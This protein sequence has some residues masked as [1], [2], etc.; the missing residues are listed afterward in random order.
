[1]ELSTRPSR[2]AVDA[3]T[4]AATEIIANSDN[5]PA[6][7]DYFRHHRDR[8]A[9]DHDWIRQTRRDGETVCEVGA[10]PFF[11]TRALSLS[12][13]DVRP[14]DLPGA[15]FVAAAAAARVSPVYCDI[16]TQRL[17]FQDQCFDHVILNEVFEH[18]RI[19]LIFTMAEILRVLKQGGRLW[20]STPNLRSLRGIANLLL[21]GEAYSSA[22]EGL[23]RQYQFAKDG[24]MG[25]VREYTAVEVGSFLTAVGFKVEKVIYR[26]SYSN[27]AARLLTTAVP[28][29]KPYF[30]VLACRK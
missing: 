20:L 14:V 21:R 11:L 26:G 23:Y 28:G 29:M 12:G 18:L 3:I 16:E 27:P 1:M 24:A 15:K 10:Y 13:L 22:G 4:R 2:D 17:P 6:F 8:L 30:S 19:D 9:L 5:R 7:S 25:H